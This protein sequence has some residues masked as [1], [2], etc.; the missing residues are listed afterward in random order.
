M[1]RRERNA[2]IRDAVHT[3]QQAGKDRNVRSVRDRAMGEGLAKPDTVGGER[4]QCGSF[5]LLVSI[6]ANMIGAQ[7][8]DGDEEH[9]WRRISWDARLGGHLI[10][11]RRSEQHDPDENPGEHPGKND[12]RK[13]SRPSHKRPAYHSASAELSLVPNAS[14]TR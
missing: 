12:R 9:V 1:L 14:L 7:R 13:N 11:G 8:V 4:V 5:D 3:R 2:K 6:A 10:P